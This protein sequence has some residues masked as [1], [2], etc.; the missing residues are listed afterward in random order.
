MT[1]ELRTIENELADTVDHIVFTDLQIFSRK[2]DLC[3]VYLC[4][5]YLCTVFPETKKHCTQITQLQNALGIHA[6][7]GLVW[8][9]ASCVSVCT[10]ND[11]QCLWKV[12]ASCS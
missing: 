5:V 11:I 9:P 1:Y 3:T 8:V 12:V 4:T 6:G 2:N 7:V 10:L